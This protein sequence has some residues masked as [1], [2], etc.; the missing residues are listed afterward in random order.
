MFL[1][2]RLTNCWSRNPLRL[3]LFPESVFR[4]ARSALAAAERTASDTLLIVSA[5]LASTRHSAALRT[6]KPFRSSR[7]AIRSRT[8]G[9][10]AADLK[11]G[12]PAASSSID[13]A[14][15]SSFA[16]APRSV[17]MSRALASRNSLAS[18]ASSLNA[19]RRLKVCSSFSEP[20]FFMPGFCGGNCGLA[21]SARPTET[22]S[23]AGGV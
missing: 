9:A 18:N 17:S 2:R 10:L 5:S 3:P 15:F 6:G 11:E 4:S 8:G 22:L 14:V 12:L 21:P 23:D 16:D 20:A 13:A 7:R 19:W 1:S